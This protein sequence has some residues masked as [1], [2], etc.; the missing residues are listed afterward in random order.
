MIGG[1]PAEMERPVMKRWKVTQVTIGFDSKTT[2]IEFEAHTVKVASRGTL[3]A[4]V[5]LKLVRAFN[6]GAW[7]T[8]EEVT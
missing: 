7:H 3:E 8:I 2:T 4:Y 6:M 5:D 1:A